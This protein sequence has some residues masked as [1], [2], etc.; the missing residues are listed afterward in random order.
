[1]QTSGIGPLV[2]LPFVHSVTDRHGRTRHYFRRLG[3][4]S[5]RLPGAVGS[6]EFNR[7]YEVAKAGEAAARI[8]IGSSR[9]KPGSVAAA[10]ALYFGSIAFGN[11]APSTQRNRRWT[12]E[13]FRE[14]Y[15]E[16]SFAT[17]RRKHVE[18][19]L[20]RKGA[21][22]HAARAFV[23]ALRSVVT[24]AI[25][26]GLRDDDP[27]L[28]LRVNVR[29]RGGYRTWTEDEIAQFEAAHPI[30]SRARLAFALALFTGQRRSDVIRIG[31]QH[32]RDGFI[33]VRQQKTGAALQ[34]PVHPDLQEILA[35][36]PASTSL[37]YL[38][39][40]AGAPFTANGFTDWF[41]KMRIEAELPPGLSAHGLR[42]ATCRRLAE[43]G[44]SA[45]QI[46]AISGHATLAEVSRYTKA[47]DQKRLAEAA[48]QAM[49]TKGDA[50]SAASGKSS[51]TSG[52]QAAQPVEKK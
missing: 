36:H 25:A 26:A 5:V 14:D 33:A 10:V 24:V 20:A 51:T 52:K 13:R 27:T 35:A 17:L 6:A 34:I 3:F 45:N 50:K 41:R 30:G 1:M 28:D 40:A 21:T 47:A 8:E 44:C 42:K 39:T 31:R 7:A 43:A 4:K 38:T 29:D 23:K 37:T 18:D 12:L 11:L 22:P 15:G 16:L 2:T 9:S 49:R 19:M 48:M 46:A 32:V